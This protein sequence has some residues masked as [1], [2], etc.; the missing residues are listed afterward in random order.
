VEP[1]SYFYAGLSSRIALETKQTEVSA[2]LA[3][4]LSVWWFGRVA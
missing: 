2:L 4:G 1:G 3:G